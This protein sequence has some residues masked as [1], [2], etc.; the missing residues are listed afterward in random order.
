MPRS[1]TSTPHTLKPTKGQTTANIQP[2]LQR[3][4]DLIREETR[5]PQLNDNWPQHEEAFRRAST[6]NRSYQ[7]HKHR[8]PKQKK[9]YRR[10]RPKSIQ[11]GQNPD[12]VRK[13]PINKRPAIRKVLP[14]PGRGKR[15]ARSNRRRNATRPDTENSLIRMMQRLDI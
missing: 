2:T 13:G 3:L 11:S 8:F 1:R 14:E 7:S 5:A 15:R 9:S 12:G 6:A 10:P 4:Q